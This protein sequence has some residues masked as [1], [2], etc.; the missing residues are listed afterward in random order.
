VEATVQ[1]EQS[2]LHPLLEISAH[3]SRTLE[4]DLLLPKIVDCLFHLFTQADRCFIILAE[5]GT[6]RLSS[7]PQFLIDFET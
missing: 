6:T 1:P 3:L 5:E 2:S 7:R 4:L